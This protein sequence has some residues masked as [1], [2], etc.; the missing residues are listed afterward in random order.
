M[1]VHTHKHARMHACTQRSFTHAGGLPGLATDGNTDGNWMV[2]ARAFSLTATHSHA[3][4]EA[5]KHADTGAHIVTHVCTQQGKS[6]TCTK[7][8]DK[9]WWKVTAPGAYG[10]VGLAVCVV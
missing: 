1:P 3:R 2:R 10:L 5:H 7:Q 6:V 9:P 8:E 4:A